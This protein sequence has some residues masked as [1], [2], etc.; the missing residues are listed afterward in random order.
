M[1][2]GNRIT[3]LEDDVRLFIAAPQLKVL[4]TK[5]D[6]SKMPGLSAGLLQ[7]AAATFDGNSFRVR[8]LD[9]VL[10]VKTLTKSAVE[11]AD[12]IEETGRT[13][14]GNELLPLQ[15]PVSVSRNSSVGRMNFV[16]CHRLLSILADLGEQLH[17]FA[18]QSEA[19]S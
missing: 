7:A 13:H 12:H 18:T 9:A 6:W 17:Q 16:D 14:A 5:L 4:V 2:F 15:P 10:A 8:Y 19:L 1:H 11:I 3:S